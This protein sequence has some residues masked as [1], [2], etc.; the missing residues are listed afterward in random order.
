MASDPMPFSNE[1]ARTAREE[2]A[3]L[4]ARAQEIRSRGERWL[5]RA[6]DL[7]RE[8]DRLDQRVLELDELLGRAQQLRLDLQSRHLQ[9]QRLREAATR[10]LLRRRGLRA[11]IH[12]REWF[13]LITEEGIV[14]VGKDPLAT[15]LTQITR[16][17]VVVRVEGGQGVYELDPHGLYEGARAHL[18]EALAMQAAAP[19]HQATTAE[20]VELARRKLDAVLEAR[21]LLLHDWIRTSADVARAE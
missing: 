21:T 7:L 14:V 2:A 12:Y 1:F 19:D 20:E 9:G 15:F 13:D 4:A 16:S 11:S 3:R 10:I 6:G 8:A 5:E 18:Q 17:P